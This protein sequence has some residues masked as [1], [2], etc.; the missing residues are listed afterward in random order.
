MCVCVCVCVCVCSK[1]PYE[2]VAWPITPSD[3]DYDAVDDNNSN[4]ISNNNDNKPVFKQCHL[5]VKNKS[6]RACVPTITLHMT[7]CS[8][9]PHAF[10][11]LSTLA[12]A[13]R[14]S[15]WRAGRLAAPGWS[16]WD[17]STPHPGT[18]LLQTEGTYTTMYY[19]HLSSTMGLVCFRLKVRTLR[20]ILSNYLPQWD[21]SASDWRYVHYDVFYS[22]IFHNGNGLLQTQG[23]YTKQYPQQCACSAVDRR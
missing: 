11:R 6:E 19:I 22:I 16:L 12:R 9:F 15:G 10:H 2:K 13:A 21:W 1:L 8:P 18:G 20:C 3:S 5:S 17:A 7:T 23:T 14:S 4:K